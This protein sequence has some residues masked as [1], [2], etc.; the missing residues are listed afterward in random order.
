MA[1]I[2]DIKFEIKGTQY[3]VHVNVNSSGEFSANIPK[4]VAE[5]LNIREKLLA[6]TLAPLEKEF[7]DAIEK[8]KKAETK[9]ELFILIR[10]GAGG[11][12][13]Y[14][15][16]GSALF[17][18]NEKFDIRTDWGKIDNIVGFD[19]RV[20]IKETIDTQEHW[21]KANLGKSFPHWDKE[22]NANPEKYFKES[23]ID[24]PDTYK[25]IPFSQAALD[26][27]KVA[28]E[29]LRAASEQLF[30]FIKQD[31]AEIEYRLTN[32]KLLN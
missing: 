20:G 5:A 15:K 6:L 17:S 19:F 30:N 2:T 14:N 26:T 12:F 22:E 29:K 3:V 21:Y 8:Y 32:Q 1:K 4:F 11:K 28:H 23:K 24:R 9:Q 10:Y 31:E 18:T 27:L 7:N 13:C 25:K 16:Q